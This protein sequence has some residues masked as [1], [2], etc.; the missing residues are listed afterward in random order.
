ML[1]LRESQ[2]EGTA[3]SLRR[4]IRASFLIFVVVGALSAGSMAAHASVVDA[5][6]LPVK[7]WTSSVCNGFATWEHRLTKLGSSNPA[8]A[9]AAKTAIVTFLTGATRATGQLAKALKRA[10]VPSIQ[11]G[12]EIAAAIISSVKS[13]RTTYVGAKTT[14][15]ALPTD[16]PAAAQALAT[17]LQAGETTLQA[18]VAEAAAKYPA[19]KLDK[20]F[21]ATK[22]C[23][24][25]A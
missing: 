4:P 7:A 3:M 17:Q 10:G 9:A 12:K 1:T 15:A 21:A 19:P 2:S 13:L 5:K 22:A 24:K 25:L 11:H 23:T 14:A 6:A 18:S 8:D 16:D 20:A